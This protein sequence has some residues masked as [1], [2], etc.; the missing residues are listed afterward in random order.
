MRDLIQIVERTQLNE[1][2]LDKEIDAIVDA[3]PDAKNGMVDRD[4]VLNKGFD[5]ALALNDEFNRLKRFAISDDFI[6]RQ[7]FG[8][9]AEK[10]KLKGMYQNT[11]GF[12]MVKKDEFGRYKSAGSGSKGSAEAQN[13]IGLLPGRIA[14]KMDIP[15]KF[16]KAA[17]ADKKSDSS[18]EEKP[19][20]ELSIPNITDN[21]A[22]KY[23]RRIK[24]LEKKMA[25]PEG[26]PEIYS[27]KFKSV[28]GDLYNVLN[29][30]TL[31]N[32]EQKEFDFILQGF[33]KALGKDAIYTNSL[34]REIKRLLVKHDKSYARNAASVGKED[35]TP[36]IAAMM[37]VATGD[38]KKSKDA[39]DKDKMV[40]GALQKFAKSGKGGL[41]NDPDEVEAIKEL[42]TRLKEMGIGMTV[43]GK[44]SKGTV[45]A[46][47]RI[48]EMLGEKQDGDAG[49]KTIDAIIKMGNVP[50][51]ITF[52]DDLKRLAELSKKIKKES[53]DFR[54]VISILEG[55][56]LLEALT[57]AEQKEYDD[58][59]KK[60]KAKF[61]DPEYQIA[62]PKSVK[63]L[64]SQV[65]RKSADDNQTSS[66]QQ[67]GQDADASGEE[68]KVGDDSDDDSTET[69]EIIDGW[70]VPMPKDLQEKLGL[71]KTKDYFINIYTG[72]GDTIFISKSSKKH[73]TR[74]AYAPGDSDHTLV[75]D[76]LDSIGVKTKKGDPR[77]GPSGE[78]EKT[79]SDQEAGKEADQQYDTQYTGN[80]REDQTEF[81]KGIG[82]GLNATEEMDDMLDAIEAKIES[83]KMDMDGLVKLQSD[84][85]KMIQVLVTNSKVPGSSETNI[86]KTY[87]LVKKKDLD[88]ATR[89]LKSWRDGDLANLITNA[90]T[91]KD[92]KP[93]DKKDDGGASEIK[94]SPQ[95]LDN[96]KK[97]VE[98]SKTFD[99]KSIAKD[100]AK[101]AD[102][103]IWMTDED[104]IYKSL[105]KIKDKVQYAQV[106]SEFKAI[107]AKS[108]EAMIKSET[109][110]GT[111]KKMLGIIYK[112]QKT[113][114]SSATTTS[115]ANSTGKNLGDGK[116]V[117]KMPA[118]GNWNK[119]WPSLG[120]KDLQ[121][122][123]KAQQAG[124]VSVDVLK[125][126]M[127]YAGKDVTFIMAA[128]TTGVTSNA[129]NT[130]DS[131]VP[132]ATSAN[133]AEPKDL[134]RVFKNTDDYYAW[135]R[136]G[137]PKEWPPKNASNQNAGKDADNNTES[138][139]YDMTKKVNEA[140]SMNISMSGDN[141]QEVTELVAILRNA[142]M[143]D[144]GPVTSDM[145]P[146]MAST[147]K[148]IDEP[149][150]MDKPQ[151]SCG[152]GEDEVEEGEWDNS[153]DEEYK[154]DDYM[155]KDI[156]GGLNRPK[157]KGA[158]R[159][160]DPAIHNEEV[161]KYKAQLAKDLEEA[162]GK[163]TYKKT[164]K[165]YEFGGKV[166]KSEQQARTAEQQAKLKKMGKKD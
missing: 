18:K 122:F 88:R 143:Q 77:K 11:G 127:K 98:K 49:P 70:F 20:K 6:E 93:T 28:F 136:A 31:S 145:M 140:A 155:N 131:K 60:H 32:E 43:D 79:S 72:N 71:R 92:T 121:S 80:F 117:V 144:A 91:A 14:K 21:N 66:D 96:L 2:S 101:A 29:E 157:E 128:Q 68:S 166:Y 102:Y 160:K 33:K 138:K 106:D 94:L 22:M 164:D 104:L 82:L 59:M 45:D 135:I 146:P 23:I 86:F 47:K 38:D 30:A 134:P 141:A 24:E 67:A 154:D 116:K 35:P 105:D 53:N 76:Y 12:V 84:I 61:D 113:E 44:Y 63:D 26:D 57:N 129:N 4:A 34:K 1:A 17:D 97:D 56:N 46:V 139:E 8:K 120:F 69:A 90:T 162:Y 87:P 58:L 125:N 163:F 83:D 78:E 147:I 159:A 132:S 137:K 124:G 107:T 52:Y 41:A 152:M 7:Y 9:V 19:S 130:D 27:S 161:N 151:G 5:K 16:A 50:G 36:D 118:D 89:M 39:K 110:F 37:G 10:Y 165:G 103:G 3:L 15:L 54:Y 85:N 142:G 108:I 150:M 149:P 119:I 55:G 100:L 64:I 65:I 51:I 123:V 81:Y 111:E 133:N 114:P 158:L 153:P 156:A 40:S 42:Q 25:K 112:I 62:L 13:N 75:K 148:M 126:P 109:S 73:Q 95:A 74:I 48:Q 99:A 115:D